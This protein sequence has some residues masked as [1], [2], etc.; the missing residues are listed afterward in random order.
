MHMLRIRALMLAMG[1]LLA[2][3]A[4]AQQFEELP[5]PKPA[6]PAP[7]AGGN[8]IGIVNIQ[9]AMLR[10]QEGRK[11]ALDLQERFNP[12]QAELLKLREEIR[13]LESQLRTRQRTLS[14]EE[15]VRL[16]RELEQKRKQA[17]RQEQDLRD[18]RTRA[19]TD[20]VN[21]IG[22]EMQ[23]ILDQYAR[24]KNLSIIF[25]IFQGGPV[26]YATPAVDITDEI[27]R[28]YDQAHPVETTKAA[29]ASRPAAIPPKQPPP[30]K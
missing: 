6:T 10:T 29:P 17:S 4:G 7:A 8:K 27:V 3:A 18:D 2:V 13:D 14:N 5:T 15:Q 24:E 19:E 25:N 11:A 21:R 12:R 23:R 9:A 26:V 30:P 1:L 22:Q 16:L 20:L 28:L